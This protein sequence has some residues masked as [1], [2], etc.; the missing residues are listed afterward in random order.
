MIAALIAAPLVAAQ[1]VPLP[2]TPIG[3]A[4]ASVL[5]APFGTPAQR[6]I[7]DTP[8]P[9]RWWAELG[10]P[11]LDALVETALKASPDIAVAE[12]QLRQARELARAAGGG[13]FPQVDA[14]FQTSRARVSNVA[15]TPLADPNATLYT[16]HTAQVSVSYT[17]DVFG[18]VGA[19]VRSARAAAKA[20]GWRSGAARSM[21]IANLVQ[22]VVQNAALTDQIASAREAITANREILALIKR[23]EQLGAV[24][25]ADVAAQETALAAAEGTLPLLE[26]AQKHSQALIAVFTGR[27]PGTDLPDLPTLD[28]LKLPAQL[29][30]SLPAETVAHRPDIQAAAAQMEGAAADAKVAMAARLPSFTL[31]AGYGG[32]ATRFSD[33]FASGNPFWMLLGGVTQPIFHAGSLMHQSHAAKAALEAAQAQYR[34]TAL[35]G[36]ADLS[37]ALTALKTDG[38]AL[39]AAT[40]GDS[41]SAQSLSF[42]RRQ[43]ELGAVGTYQLLPVVAAR[44]AARETYVQARAAR[45][46][47][48]IALYQALGGGIT[49]P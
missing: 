28:E 38:D 44:A 34:S 32:S 15:A 19:R 29:P 23:R 24:G 12:A 36:F 1:A 3:N 21:V 27:V 49:A 46:A 11:K 39:E 41:A 5:V 4:P 20:Q 26:R 35:Q 7:P 6:V 45:L 48:T 43:F 8:V 22:A 37:D 9:P 47:D 16:L 42:T 14:G 30:L 13:Q 33:M 31:S 10:S 17:L 2:P 40:R 18:G 25:A